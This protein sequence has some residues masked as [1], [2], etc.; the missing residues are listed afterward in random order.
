MRHAVQLSQ[1]TVLGRRNWYV[2]LF[3]VEKVLDMIRRNLKDACNN[4]SLRGAW[5]RNI[6]T[7]VRQLL[8]RVAGI[9]TRIA[10]CEQFGAFHIVWVTARYDSCNSTSI[11]G[12]KTR[13]MNP[14]SNINAPLWHSRAL[15]AI[16]SQLTQVS[17]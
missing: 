16:F 17:N 10:G 7:G 2:G 5:N 1:C 8:V 13:L 14:L 11:L 4:I 15:F 12:I 9:H 3:I 6:W